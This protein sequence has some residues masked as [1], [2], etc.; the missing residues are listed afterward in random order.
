M[1]TSDRSLMGVF[2]NPW[3]VRLAGGFIAAAIALLDGWLVWQSL[4]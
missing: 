1:F 3:W 4:A 2:T